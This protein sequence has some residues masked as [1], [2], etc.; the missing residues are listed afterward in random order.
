MCLSHGNSL[1]SQAGCRW[2][3][4]VPLSLQGNPEGLFN[5]QALNGY[6]TCDRDGKGIHGKPDGYEDN[7]VEFGEKSHNI[8][9]M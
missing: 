9:P 8:N 4:L 1:P 3:T 2:N 7:G 5:P 6:T